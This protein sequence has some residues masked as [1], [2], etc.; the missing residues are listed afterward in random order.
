MFDGAWDRLR[1]LFG[2]RTGGTAGAPR[3]RRETRQHNI[4]EAAAVY[5]A[6]CAEDDERRIEEAAGWVSPEALSFGVNELACRAVIAL[7]RE[8]GESPQSVARTLLGLPA[9]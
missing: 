2:P 5:V 6:A 8:R 7:A 1:K 3:A 9:A 4:F